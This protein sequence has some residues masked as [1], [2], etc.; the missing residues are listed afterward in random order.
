LKH[1]GTHNSHQREK[2]L[3]LYQAS[4]YTWWGEN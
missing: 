2:L 4:Y 3:K 1:T